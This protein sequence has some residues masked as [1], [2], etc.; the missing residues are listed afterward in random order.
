M[1]V[2]G[3]DFS[4]V[5]LVGVLN[6]DHLLHFPNF[7]AHERCFQML[8]QVAGRAGRSEKPG[9]VFVQT[10]QPHH[11]VIEQIVKYNYE[12]HFEQQLKE[13]K[14]FEY[15]PF[16]RLIRV[17]FKNKNFHSLN[18]STEW[19]AN[20]LKQLL[21]VKILGPTFPIV[22]RIR[23]LYLKEILIKI[24]SDHSINSTKKHLLKVQHSFESIAAFKSTRINI[25]VDPF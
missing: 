5:N 18:Q 2:K 21:S 23:N 14:Q 20:V 16:C 13:R 15:P 10:F 3:L 19:Y 25:D 9:R 22:S 12:D 1:L 17:T 8:V 24:G 6:A 7:R 4:N 11:P